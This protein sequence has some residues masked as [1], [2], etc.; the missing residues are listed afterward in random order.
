MGSFRRGPASV[1]GP[2]DPTPSGVVPR[3]RPGL[4]GKFAGR[5]ADC[6][7]P[8]YEMER[9]PWVATRST[10]GGR[11]RPRRAGA[12]AGRSMPSFPASMIA[13]STHRRPAG[14]APPAHPA[15]PAYPAHQVQSADR[16]QLHTALGEALEA[17]CF[18]RDGSVLA[19]LCVGIDH[20]GRRAR[21]LGP[22]SRDR[23]LADLAVRLA[24]HARRRSDTV[25]RCGDGVFA[26]VLPHVG[27]AESAGRVA[28][29]VVRE[30][31][32]PIW[33]DGVE[34]HLDAGVGI[35]MS[36]GAGGPGEPGTLLRDAEH[37][38]RRA[39]AVAGGHRPTPIPG[40][41]TSGRG[42]PWP[43]GGDGPGRARTTAG[44][45]RRAPR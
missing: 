43:S 21:P 41:V 28:G 23:L 38:R 19:V 12:S 4:A 42:G 15:P 45:R 40:S 17:G 37:A 29:R 32:R 27:T 1:P 20:R 30:V 31:R 35:A 7:Q 10:S 2:G 16:L 36:G 8:G 44:R 25:V 6:W 39:Q 14:P 9:V 11:R 18:A 26:M 22:R 33:L 34:H 24:A 3:M 5:L 13:E